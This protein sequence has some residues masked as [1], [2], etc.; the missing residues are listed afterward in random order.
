MKTMAAIE[1]CIRIYYSTFPVEARPM[2]VDYLLQNGLIEPNDN[3]WYSITE[4]GRI[5][6]DAI[7]NLELPVQK[8]V[9][10]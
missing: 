10:P 3:D 6:C 4:R 2:E 8:W 7:F 5:Y 1:L 9:M